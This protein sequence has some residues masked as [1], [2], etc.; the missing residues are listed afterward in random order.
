MQFVELSKILLHMHC[1][2]TVIL[3]MVFK[4]VHTLLEKRIYFKVIIDLSDV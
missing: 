1:I 3:G 4:K 2:V